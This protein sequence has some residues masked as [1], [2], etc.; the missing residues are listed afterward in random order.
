MFNKKGEEPRIIDETLEP[1]GGESVSEVRRRNISVI[2]PTLQFKG[3]LSANEDLVIEGY[4]EGKIA[5][6]E[7]NL[8]IGAKGRVK[9]DIHAREID[10]LGELDGDVRGD[11]LVRL[12][13]T[14]VVNGNIS[15]PR[16]LIEDGACFN[17][18]IE[19]GQPAKDEMDAPRP[20]DKA[21]LTKLAVADTS[22]HAPGS[23]A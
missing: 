9:A 23:S 15:A 21:G 18:S 7:K 22:S 8:T 20:K 17:G 4:I 14:A 3:E 1:K 10:I 2:G 11:E 16:V 12:K 6:Q 13:K 5:H 19:M